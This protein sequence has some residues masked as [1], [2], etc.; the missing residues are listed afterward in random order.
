MKAV[1]YREY[2]APEVLQYVDVPIPEPKAEEVLIK[3]HAS[4][5]TLGDCELRAFR[6]PAFVWLPVRIMFGIFRPK[7]RILGQEL[8]GTVAAVGERVTNWTVGDEVVAPTLFTLGAHAQFVCLPVKYPIINK[9]TNMSFVDAATIPT[10]GIN[11]LHFL[12]KANIKQ[13]E[14]VLIIGAGGS[15]GTYAVQLA[16]YY[17]A[18]V[19]AV[20]RGSKL[21]MLK[22]IGADHVIDYVSQ[23]YTKE[24]AAYDVIFDIVCV[25]RLSKLTRMLLPHGRYLAG[26]PGLSRILAAKLINYQTKKVITG[27]AAYKQRDMEELKRLVEAGHIKAVIDRSYPLSQTAEAHRYVDTGAKAGNVVINNL[28]VS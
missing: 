27:M 25:E 10:G 7:R 11:A 1:V 8:A 4:T 22:A 16:K 19:T 2:G 23:D 24:K 17:G 14:K 26:N 28:A 15:I 13:G 18:E 21:E 6:F 5:V 9:P 20:D 12:R 3:I